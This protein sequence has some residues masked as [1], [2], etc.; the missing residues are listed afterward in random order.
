MKN[1][2]IFKKTILLNL[3]INSLLVLFISFIFQFPIGVESI[4]SLN[5]KEI[6]LEYLN[7]NISEEDYI[8]GIGDIV[9]ISVSEN[10][11]ELTKNHQIDSAGTVY[12][13]KIG[14][15]FIKDLTINELTSLLQKK[16]KEYIKDPNPEILVIGYRPVRI[17]IEGEIENPGFFTLPGSFKNDSLSVN[18]LKLRNSND[19]DLNYGISDSI[20]DNGEPNNKITSLSLN[21]FPTLFDALQYAGGV[22]AYS[23][24]SNIEIIRKNNISDG[25]GRK[26]AVIN[27]LSFINGL[28]L[29]QNIRIY[30]GDLIKIKRSEEQLM[31]QLSKAIK[32][33]LNPKY[34]NVSVTGTVPLPGIIKA[35]KKSTLN[36]A[37]QLAGGVKALKGPIYFTRFNQD[38]SVDT[39]KFNYKR[40]RKRGSLQNPYLKNGDIINVGRNPISVVN[41]VLKEITAPI[42]PIYSTYQIFN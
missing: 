2:S 24:L 26:I 42:I 40:S 22:T 36:D 1:F 17:L 9:Q 34:I 11:N 28:D 30:D 6:D 18:N 32:S 4:P 23:N 8:L 31:G 7:K 33:N 35:S 37:I 20:F 14:R 29:G 12:L 21:Y 41:E 13:P 16:Y 5:A 3:N 25:S 15:V 39:R 27:F 10:I 19:E 38:G